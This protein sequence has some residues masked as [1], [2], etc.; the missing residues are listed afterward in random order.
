M[1]PYSEPERRYLENR[2]Q[3]RDFNWSSGKSRTRRYRRALELPCSEPE[4]RFL[5]RRLMEGEAASAKN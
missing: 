2:R 5:E 4:R 1:L 3:K